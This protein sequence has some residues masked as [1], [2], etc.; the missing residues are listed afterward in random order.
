MQTV[1]ALHAE[2]MMTRV[3]WEADWLEVSFGDGQTAK[4]PAATLRDEHGRPLRAPIRQV[5]LVG[6]HE[7]L[8]QAEDGAFAEVPWDFARHLTED[9]DFQEREQRLAEEGRGLLGGRVRRLRKSR[10]LSQSEAARRSGLGRVTLA[11]LEKG[12]QSPTLDTLEK[13]ARGLEV[14]VSRLLGAGL[15]GP[16]ALTAEAW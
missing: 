8:I 11:R 12:E 4:I 5:S 3:S 15:D 16:P 2:R 9:R 1:I 7:M 14:S 6:F 10:G 13:I